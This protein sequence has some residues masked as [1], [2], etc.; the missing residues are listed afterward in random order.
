LLDT[1]SLMTRSV[2]GIDRTYGLGRQADA[3]MEKIH[4]VREG[5][6]PAWRSDGSYMLNIELVQYSGKSMQRGQD[7]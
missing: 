1:I 5:Y 3:M 7:R 6:R 4:S 2:L